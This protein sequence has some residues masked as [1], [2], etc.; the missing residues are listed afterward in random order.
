MT[1][2]LKGITIIWI[3]CPPAFSDGSFKIKRVRRSAVILFRLN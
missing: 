2:G 3:L 1:V